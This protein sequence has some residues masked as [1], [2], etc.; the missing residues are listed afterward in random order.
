MEI[1][2][3]DRRFDRTSFSC[4]KPELDDWL[5]TKAG[6]Q[7]RSN[8][9]RTFLAVHGSR[10]IGYYATTTYRLGL[11]EVAKMYGAGKR[12]YP[13]PAVLLARLAVD[14]GFQGCGIGSKLLL[15][16]LSQIA[17]ASRHVGFEVVVVHAIDRDAVTFY[18]QR[19]F[20]QFEDHG[21]HL[22]M[23]VKDLLATFKSVSN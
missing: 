14:T 16:A 13:I 15:H 6:Q 8:N 20:I 19:G 22:F 3:F 12:T 17:E 7:E 11:D 1:L 18:A 21:L 2:A 4:G 5:K 10:V 9:T 23:P